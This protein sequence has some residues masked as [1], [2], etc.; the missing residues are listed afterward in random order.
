M[1]E[2]I[3][4]PTVGLI[5]IKDNKL[6]LAY[7]KNKQAWYLPGGKIDYGENAVQSLKREIS[8]ELNLVINPE[9]LAFYC[10]ISAPAYG[11]KQHVIMEQDCYLYELND[12]IKP[13]NEI[14]AV[15]FFDYETYKSEP[16]QVIGVLEVFDNL[17]KDQILR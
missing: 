15:N 1:T 4:L 13:G 12:D 5:V 17:I 3:V 14:G 9:L 8:E 10:H 2:N 7:S 6:L 16:I 11:E